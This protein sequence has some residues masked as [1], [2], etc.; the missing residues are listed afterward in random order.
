MTPINTPQGSAQRGSNLK[1]V[2]AVGGLTFLTGAGAA[3][4]LLTYQ[5]NQQ[6]AVLERLAIQLETM[7][8][9][10]VTR[11]APAD[12]LAL[13]MAPA[14]TVPASADASVTTPQP[15]TELAQSTVAVAPAAEVAAAEVEVAAATATPPATATIPSATA[16]LAGQSE[17]RSDAEQAEH[18][19]RVAEAIAAVSRNRMR[20]LTEGVVAGLYDVSVTD[21]VT[22][23]T[24]VAL[25]SR[26]AST[27]AA[28]VQELLA[29]AAADGTIEVP[30]AIETAEGDVD[31]S[32]LL[33]DL[34]QRSL[35][36]EG[37]VEAATELRQR[38]F[39]A[40]QA[41]TEIEAG[42]RYYT[43]E[44][45]DSLAYI[46]LQFYGSTNQYQRIFD[47]NRDT[48]TSPDEIRV[49]QRLLIP[50]T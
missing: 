38:A 30:D 8:Q 20:M 40:S 34:V 22:G 46:S 18:D 42:Q 26:N 32:T 45:G 10:T 28:E 17:P 43:V 14:T 27:T 37:E 23:E 7:Q 3:V 2:A 5:Q 21:E 35:E 4:A 11:D 9:T 50:Q 29:Q 25:D 19:A 1:L 12:T 6:A 36:A 47:A 33:L 13:P 49:G 15:V 39:Q 44:R 41:E 31:T 24:R 48:L 16:A